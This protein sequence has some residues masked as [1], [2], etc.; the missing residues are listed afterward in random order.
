MMEEERKIYLRNTLDVKG[1]DIS[2][3]SSSYPT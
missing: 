2:K 1:K 3:G